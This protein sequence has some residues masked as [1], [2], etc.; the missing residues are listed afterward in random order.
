MPI[1]RT[2]HLRRS[3]QNGPDGQPSTFHLTSSTVRERD[4]TSNT[5]TRADGLLAGISVGNPDA[6]FVGP[7]KKITT[8]GQGFSGGSDTPAEQGS[9]ARED[10]VESQ[11]SEFNI[12]N[13]AKSA[14]ERVQNIH[15]N[16]R[17]AGAPLPDTV[18]WPH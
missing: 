11:A 13:I 16:L 8:V 15:K 14:G 4:T 17:K 10:N 1:H 3:V 9:A 6:S 2:V 18:R 12:N 5:N 7:N